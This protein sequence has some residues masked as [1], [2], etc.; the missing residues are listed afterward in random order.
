MGGRRFVVAWQDDVNTFFGKYKKESNPRLRGRWQALWLLRDGK[1]LAEVAQ[2]VGVH[3]R[4]VE[5]WVGWYRAGGLA[6]VAQH[7]VGGPRRQGKRRLSD[8]QERLLSEK[9]ARDGFPTIASAI[10]WTADT[11]KVELSLTQMRDVF[12]GLKLRKKVPRPVSDRAS[13]EAQAAWKKGD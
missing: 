6:E 1:R 4:T 7:Q 2:I 10:G 11:L 9:A 3:Y 8:E 5:E 12:K 13:G